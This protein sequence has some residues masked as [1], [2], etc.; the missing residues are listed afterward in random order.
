MGSPISLYLSFMGRVFTDRN[1]FDVK[2]MLYSSYCL[3]LYT[4]I[5]CFIVSLLVGIMNITVL[6]YDTLLRYN[7]E[8]D[9]TKMFVKRYL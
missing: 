8:E 6:V 1:K 2:N 4:R 7:Y 5:N 9:D 3:L